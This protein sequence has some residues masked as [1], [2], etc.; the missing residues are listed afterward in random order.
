MPY[1]I[2]TLYTTSAEN[3]VV[4][5]DGVYDKTNN[6][7]QSLINSDLIARVVS[8]ESSNSSGGFGGKTFDGPID[9]VFE[10]VEGDMEINSDVNQYYVPSLQMDDSDITYYLTSKKCFVKGKAYESADGTEYWQFSPNF[11]S[12]S[13]YQTEDDEG[14]IDTIKSQFYFNNGNKTMYSWDNTNETFNP[15]ADE[16]IETQEIMNGAVTKDKLSTELK[17]AIDAIAE[18][19]NKTFPLSASLS[20]TISGTK[21]YTGTSTINP[22]LTINVTR[23]SI[24]VESKNTLTRTVNGADSSTLLSGSVAKTASDTVNIPSVENGKVSVKYSLSATYGAQS[25][26]AS[27]SINYYAPIY[28]GRTTS[29]SID[30]S[31]QSVADKYPTA[32]S[33]IT[34]LTINF[35]EGTLNDYLI[36]CVPSCFTITHAHA[37]GFQIDEAQIVQKSTVAF[38]VGDV[39]VTYNYW[40]IGPQKAAEVSVIYNQ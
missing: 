2:G 7:F 19:E 36:L 15:V 9:T 13:S 32:K 22:E 23:K 35:P 37:G 17:L 16:S 38:I 24:S 34:G 5:T 29:S 12:N 1:I 27:A 6:K 33:N 25:A 21:E 8:L 28:Y 39:T 3:R 20:S 11:P 40:A 31:F 4:E 18:I 10:T 26:T 14:N 30:A